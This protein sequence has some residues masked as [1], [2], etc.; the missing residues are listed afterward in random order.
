MTADQLRKAQHTVPR[1]LL[2]GFSVDGQVLTCRRD[3]REFRE[4][5]NR[6]SVATHFYSVEDESGSR[7]DAVERWLASDI[8]DGFHALLPDLV[9]GQQP[10]KGSG[11]TVARY[12]AS[13]ATRSRAT[14]AMQLDTTP[15]LGGLSVLLT[16]ADN[17]GLN[18]ADLSRDDLV[19]LRAECE[20]FFLKWFGPPSKASLLRTAL[21]VFDQTVPRLRHYVWRVLL[22][23]TELLLGDHPVV[24]ISHEETRFA[25]LLPEGCT[26]FLPLA[27]RT[28]LIGEPP[29]FC[30]LAL[31]NG[32]VPVLV[33]QLTARDCH[34]NVY[35]RPGTPWPTQVTL[36]PDRASLV[37]QNW[38]V[39]R[40]T[41]T[42]EQAGTREPGLSRLS[43]PGAQLLMERLRTHKD[44]HVE[45][46]AER[47][48]DMIVS[49]VYGAR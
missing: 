18:L 14:E 5:I 1:A 20:R 38:S 4:T 11:Q 12:V 34:S 25:G 3:G 26:A 6:A 36:A 44:G 13:L 22:T 43:D 40:R 19:A 27:P 9:R 49:S 15:A 8:E 7:D 45:G 30:R 29:L 24:S 32:R 17:S 21:W 41:E 23:E 10:P 2:A 39:S 42:E 47:L 46:I 35:R 37:H 16:M 33:N 28:L 31:D 48:T